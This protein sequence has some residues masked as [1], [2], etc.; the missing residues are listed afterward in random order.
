MT[1][2]GKRIS[3]RLRIKVE[4]GQIEPSSKEVLEECIEN[5][6]DGSYDL[7]AKKVNAAYENPS[8]YKYY[9]SGFLPSIFEEVRKRYEV[10]LGGE[11]VMPDTVEELHLM[12]RAEFCRCV[13]I[14]KDT[15]EVYN[16]AVSTRSLSDD[17][18]IKEYLESI[19]VMAVNE[20]A[21]EIEVY[22]DWRGRYECKHLSKDVK[23]AMR[24][25]ILDDA[26]SK[27]IISNIRNKHNQKVTEYAIDYAKKR[28]S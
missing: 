4:N 27:D 20:Y 23:I 21:C 6:V 5:W 16:M 17:R 7:Q 12:L 10:M 13:V 22:E 25:M 2:Q 14:N 24:D 19:A 3:D 11:R 15:N 9:F 18:F 8:R 28:L 1:A 26:K